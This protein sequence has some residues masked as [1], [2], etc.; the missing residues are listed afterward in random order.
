MSEINHLV[1]EVNR[2]RYLAYQKEQLASAI[3]K[4]EITDYILNILS[5]GALCRPAP[6]RLP[7]SRM[8]EV[9]I[10]AIR[11]IKRAAITVSGS[12]CF[13]SQRGLIS[14]L[15]SDPLHCVP[16]HSVNDTRIHCVLVAF[17]NKIQV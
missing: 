12:A 7:A 1:L 17:R 10:T 9:T 14:F 5:T 2:L 11:H 3:F 15:S 8:P 4:R 6:R 13:S 16:V